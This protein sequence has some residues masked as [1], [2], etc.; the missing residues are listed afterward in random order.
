MPA[1]EFYEFPAGTLV[2]P[3]QPQ[4][5]FGG[6]ARMLSPGDLITLVPNDYS[7]HKS[8]ALAIRYAANDGYDGTG[9]LL[10]DTV[11]ER[12]AFTTPL[13][14]PEIAATAG[15]Y[16][17]VMGSGLSSRR[18][19]S[20]L[21]TF[22]Q[23]GYLSA[24]PRLDAHETPTTKGRLVFGGQD[25]ERGGAN[26]GSGILLMTIDAPAAGR[27]ASTTGRLMA[28]FDLNGKVLPT[29]AAQKDLPVY[30]WTSHAM[31]DSPEPLSLVEFGGEIFA[32]LE[33]TDA[34][35]T[36]LSN[37][38]NNLRGGFL[39][40]T[41]GGTYIPANRS[42]FAKLVGRALLGSGSSEHPLIPS[43]PFD[44]F[45]T[46]QARSQDYLAYGQEIMRLP[47]GPVRWL[48]DATNLVAATGDNTYEM[49]DGQKVSGS[50]KA[51][52]AL[53]T[54][55]VRADPEPWKAQQEIM[56]QGA[57][58]DRDTLSSWNSA[59]QTNYTWP[60]PNAKRWL[61]AKWLRGIYN[62]DPTKPWNDQDGGRDKL[63]PLVIG[64]WTRYPSALPTTMPTGT[65]AQHLRC[66]HY[67][68]AG[69]PFNL[70][71]ARFD[72]LHPPEICFDQSLATNTVLTE[73]N[74]NLIMEVR[75]MAG[76]IDG[77]T[78]VAGAIGAVDVNGSS[79]S[80]WSR[81][82]PVLPLPSLTAGEWLPI[83]NLFTWNDPLNVGPD[84][85]KSTSGVEVRVTFRYTGHTSNDL[86]DIA[87]AANRAPLISGFKLR[88]HAPVTTLAVE[89]AR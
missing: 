58:D 87:R 85:A 54:E 9:D 56:Y 1:S 41:V 15:L 77:D 76:S 31:F 37:G 63:H 66:R 27:W 84:Q 45:S 21:G 82:A 79:F 60:N 33:V 59:N 47:V 30:I 49:H 7:K 51:P 8:V 3:V 57:Y 83:A 6:N 19:L 38:I 48:T 43:I 28:I 12:F 75:A 89:S 36:A 61:T 39:N 5:T 86:S 73:T 17:V 67:P 4:N 2:L 50:F 14:H 65:A 53:I 72:N 35:D 25:A 32:A 20:P 71:G 23:I 55:P 46:Q 64:W 70:H 11:N 13:H 18:D 40:L 24:L 69:F 22:G 52:C 62:T 44:Q 26:P 68:W 74:P 29:I 34:D 81:I 10:S 78:T 42:Q 16:Q 88:A 80:D